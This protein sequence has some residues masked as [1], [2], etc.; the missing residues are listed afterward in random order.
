MAK[1]ADSP[2]LQLIRRMVV[3]DIV[4]ELPDD[5]LLQRFC[6]G[7]DDAAF[8]SI[9]HRH[10][11]MV[12]DICRGVLS[13][14]ADAEDA[15]Q[16]TF[17]ILARQAASVRKRKSLG[18]WLH[19]VAYRTALKARL[20]S[21]TRTKHEARMQ[22]RQASPSDL[23]WS[24]VRE[25][26]HE[27]L[28]G[29]AERYRT[30]LVLCH[31]QG[32]TQDQAAKALGLS[33]GK[34]R[35]R[36]EQGQALLRARLLHRGLGL[37]A[38]LLIVTW[39][40]AASVGMAPNLALS[41]LKAAIAVA[42]GDVSTGGVVSAQVIALTQGVTKAMFLM[43]F[44]VMS[45]LIAGGLLACVG[46]SYFTRV[47][48]CT[49]NKGAHVEGKIQLQRASGEE[50]GRIDM[51]VR[52]L[53]SAMLKEREEASQELEKIGVPALMALRKVA[54]G[55]P[56]KTRADELIRR[57]EKL[58]DNPEKDNRL[59]S[60]KVDAVLPIPPTIEVRPTDR[61]GNGA[62]HR[63]A[64]GAPD[65][66]ANGAPDRPANGAPDRPANGTPDRPAT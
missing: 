20:R 42:S 62:P 7:Q 66:P 4:R 31:L 39:P 16:A 33:K 53:D 57:I 55:G 54:N 30:P 32:L 40:G 44:K 58:R 5:L 22:E 11:P 43:K 50:P 26:L 21:G 49:D 27:E 15:F 36:L 24:E 34:F 45:A 28:H 59:T 65:R 63:P 9:L 61:P 52:Q 64:N 8:N 35:G 47:V 2:I 6:T 18:S 60:G 29:L 10:G 41:T 46:A 25:I 51:L 17:L 14:E 1:V 48:Q 13:N 38:V 19:G 23:T 37:P 56:A 3:D 12:L